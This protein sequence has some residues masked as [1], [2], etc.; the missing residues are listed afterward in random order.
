MRL[1]LMKGTRFGVGLNGISLGS[2]MIFCCSRKGFKLPGWKVG[3]GEVGGRGGG[4]LTKWRLLL[5][6]LEGEVPGDEEDW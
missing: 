3:L 2:T 5:L 1:L 6:L 4:G